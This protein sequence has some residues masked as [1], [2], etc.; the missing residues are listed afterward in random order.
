MDEFRIECPECGADM[1]PEDVLASIAQE[2]SNSATKL[3]ENSEEVVH[4]CSNCDDIVSL[5]AS[6]VIVRLSINSTFA[7]V[8]RKMK[9]NETEF[10]TAGWTDDIHDGLTKERETYEKN[11]ETQEKIS[12]ILEELND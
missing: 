2:E 5:R 3:I 10:G 4:R 9:E 7:T 12:N 6:S 8:L 1:L 11:Q